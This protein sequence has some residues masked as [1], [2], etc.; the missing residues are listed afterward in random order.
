MPSIS[1]AEVGEWLGSGGW[2]PTRDI[3]ERADDLIEFRVNDAARQGSTLQA[4]DPARRFIHSYG[5]LEL[6]L[7][8]S[9]EEMLIIDPTVGYEGDVEDFAE[10][11]A[12][13]GKAIFPVGAE[14]HEYGLLVIDELGRFFY[15]HHTGFYFLGNDE[16]EAFSALL[17]GNKFVDAEEFYI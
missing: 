6:P 11:A 14:T 1:A 7:R 3:G 17:I 10:C 2:F 15:R 5:E 8:K 9:S 13:L 4:I 12:G 16:L